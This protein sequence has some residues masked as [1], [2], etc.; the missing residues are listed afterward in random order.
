MVRVILVTFV[1]YGRD[2]CPVNFAKVQKTTITIDK[3]V[4]LRERKRHTARCVASACYAGGGGVPHPVMVGGGGTS[5]SHGGG[6]PS[7]HGG[8]RRNTKPP[9]HPDLAGVPPTIQ[10]WPRYPPHHPD[11]ARAPPPPTIQ[12]W[13][14][15]PPPVEVWTDKLKTVPSPILRMRA[16]KNNILLHDTCR[17]NYKK[18]TSMCT[19]CL[20]VEG[21][22]LLRAEVMIQ[23]TPG[24][25]RVGY[26]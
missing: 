20:Y 13:L 26:S 1:I 5:S 12:T 9:H 19:H 23:N 6:T 14:G 15:Y 17:L 24:F 25:I 3:K 8:G 21:K 18:T 4:L 10:T 16:V 22:F 11:L 2:C 7:S